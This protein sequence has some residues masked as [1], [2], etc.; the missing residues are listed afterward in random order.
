MATK[1]GR[2][3]TYLEQFLPINLLDP[4]VMWSCEITWQTK[5]LRLYYHRLIAAKLAKLQTYPEGL[6]SYSH[7]TINQMILLY[8][9]T[10]WET[11]WSTFIRLVATK[12]DR[13]LSIERSLASERLSCYRRLVKKKLMVSTKF[14]DSFN[15]V[16]TFFGSSSVCASLN[17][18]RDI[19]AFCLLWKKP[20]CH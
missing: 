7:T 9:V 6:L 18:H 1:L 12:L 17:V 8:H 10:I 15:Y 4:L 19:F 11:L 13:M 2:I 20:V 16:W 5:K 3:L 14:H